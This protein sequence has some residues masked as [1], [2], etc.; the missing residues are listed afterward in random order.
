M[1]ISKEHVDE[2]NYSFT[3]HTTETRDSYVFTVGE[4]PNV[5]LE[6]CVMIP[7]RVDERIR[8]MT[9][10]A[11][12]YRIDALLECSSKDIDDDYL[13]QH[14]F[15]ADLLDKVR[16]ILKRFPHVT[17]V[18]LHDASYMPCHREWKDTLDLLTYSIALHKQTWYEAK[19]G[20]YVTPKSKYER[21]RSQ[22]EHYASKDYKQTVDFVQ[23]YSRI[24]WSGN[25][26]A[27][28][29]FEDHM[30]RIEVMY[31]ESATFPDFF[32]RLSTLVERE[33]RCKLYKTWLEEFIQSRIHVTRDWQYDLYPTRRGGKTLRK[34]RR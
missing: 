32:A 13:K 1:A 15:A 21:Y 29:V 28:K 7:D 20:A 34:R 14:S 30:K 8:S 26:Y 22:V 5:C 9:N 27:K 4:A 33:E 16:S 31:E 18:K 11:I 17:T 19:L 3:L 6:L 23:F 10:V 2:K 25:Q 24:V 12:L